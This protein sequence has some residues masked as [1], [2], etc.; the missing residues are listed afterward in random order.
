MDAARKLQCQK[1][2]GRREMEQITGEE[3]G[4]LSVG[5]PLCLSPSVVNLYPFFGWISLLKKT[6]PEKVYFFW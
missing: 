3:V 5:S 4:V 6:K 1:F 2:K